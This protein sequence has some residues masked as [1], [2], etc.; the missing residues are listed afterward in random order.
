M[1]CLSIMQT[2]PV[3]GGVGGVCVDGVSVDDGGVCVGQ[4]LSSSLAGA[5]AELGNNL[6]VRC[7]APAVLELTQILEEL[8]LTSPS[9]ELGSAPVHCHPLLNLLQQFLLTE[10]N[11][12]K[13]NQLGKALKKNTKNS[14]GHLNTD[15]IIGWGSGT[16]SDPSPPNFSR[17]PKFFFFF[18]FFFFEAFPYDYTET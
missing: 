5:W 11:N 4:Q 1:G 15:H 17:K 9:D 7:V 14:I 13:I 10:S 16:P 3:V 12:R 2:I 8:N 6:F 18:F